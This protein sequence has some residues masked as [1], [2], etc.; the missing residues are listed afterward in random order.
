MHKNNFQEITSG[1]YG[2][3]KKFMR[4]GC[5]IANIYVFIIII[6]YGA[7]FFF[8]LSYIFITV[9]VGELI[10]ISHE[11]NNTQIYLLGNRIAKIN[12]NNSYLT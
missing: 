4:Y 10:A 2:Y 3:S 12:G 7:Y 1:K 11:N 8:T 5:E 9:L 6:I